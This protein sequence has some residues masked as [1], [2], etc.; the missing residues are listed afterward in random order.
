MTT[1]IG[2]AA[3][4]SPSDNSRTLYLDLLQSSLLGLIYEDPPFPRF[5]SVEFDIKARMNGLDWPSKAHT[6]VG[7]NRLY[8]ARALAELVIQESIE[9]DFLEAG[10]WRGG[11]GI[12]LRGVLSAYDVKDRRVWLADSFEG[13]P[14]PDASSYPLDAD[15]NFH[16]FPELSVSKEEVQSNFSKYNLLDDQ[17]VFLKGWFKDTLFDAPINKIALLRL[18]GDL[19]ESTAQALEALYPKVSPNGFI[20]VDDYHCVPQCKQAIDDFFLKNK[21]QPKINDIDGVGIYWR[22]NYENSHDDG[23]VVQKKSDKDSFNPYNKNTFNQRI[24]GAPYDDLLKSTQIYEEK[25]CYINSILSQRSMELAEQKKQISTLDSELTEHKKQ[26][27]ER[28]A[29][30][31]DLIISIQSIHQ[32]N[33]WRVTAPF[34]L[35]STLMRNFF[36]RQ[37][38]SELNSDMNSTSSTDCNHHKNIEYTSDRSVAHGQKSSFF[39]IY[40]AKIRHILEP[41]P[42]VYELAR[43]LNRFI[44]KNNTNIKSYSVHQET[45]STYHISK[46]RGLIKSSS[47]FCD[48][49]EPV[50]SFQANYED[51]RNFSTYATDIKAMAFYLPQF[52]AIPEN[53][54]WWEKGFTEWTNTRKTKPLFPGH[55]QPREPHADIG[56][57]DL[58]DIEVIKKQV[59][60]A[61]AHGIHGFCFY[62]YWFH[63][64]RLLGTP[65][66]MLLNNPELEMPFCL[67]W[68]NET[69]SK[70]WDGKDHHILMKQTFSSQD[71]LEFIK[72]L[73]PFFQDPRYIRVQ[74]KP[75]LLVYRISKLPNPM[76]TAQRWRNWCR[77]NGLGEIYLVSVAH[78]ELQSDMPLDNVG[79]DAYAAFPPHN[80]HCDQMTADPE[81]FTGGY[82]FNYK[83][84]IDNYSYHYP[85]TTV[86][87]G[88]TL[89]WDNTA[90][91]GT[92]AQMYLNFSLQDY[93]RWL[94][95]VMEYTRKSF[96]PEERYLFINAWNEWAEGTYLEPDAKYGYAYLNTT[97]RALFDMPLNL[98]KNV[99]NTNEPSI[100]SS[101]YT[102]DYEYL[103]TI[104]NNNEENSLAKINQYITHGNS[105][106]I[107]E[108]GPASGY[109]TRYL[110]EEKNAV[111]DI[112]ELDPDCASLASQYARDCCVGDIEAYAWKRVFT[113]RK[114]DYILFA[115]VLEHLKNPWSLLKESTSFLKPNGKILISVPNI[116]HAQ[117]LASLYNNDFSYAN[118]GILDKTHLRFFTETTFRDMILDSGLQ[119]V[120]LKP[121][122]APILPEGCGTLRNNIKIPSKLMGLLREKH[123]ADAIQFV[124]CCQN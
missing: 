76:K 85:S 25:L 110:S 24:T 42:F 66:D 30:I 123:F 18:D 51:D 109:F 94:R 117:I 59:Q 81:I 10:V 89:G 48:A 106:E 37:T 15:S 28:Y 73:A 115:D 55:Y 34:R 46:D 69:W 113:G 116:A 43:K 87:E 45:L 86:F 121:I 72:F 22:K 78:G 40:K 19:Y 1:S 100:T 107:L 31:Q 35:S 80:F 122:I 52:H 5:G 29:L 57:Y 103:K 91:F 60:L 119:I 47:E 104:I 49:T 4:V 99:L 41:Y 108:F 114:Y 7:L 101:K 26:A 14:H 44:S 65:V 33:S 74:G 62:H 2:N 97:S 102:Q 38:N 61:K 67:C 79:F 92:N 8:N 32:S 9:G 36:V 17:V 6:M 58:T 82:R 70:K 75:V 11:V 64:K 120:D 71:D 83:S 16:T 39:V 90:R 84:G 112:A 124:A 95:N 21:I 23:L 54:A 88:C 68:A 50:D 3:S 27:T 105:L 111:V 63:G 56:Y 96:Q 20:I 13:L 93:H 98:A 77:K 12:M 53:D 118:V